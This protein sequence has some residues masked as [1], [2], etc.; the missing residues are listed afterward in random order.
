MKNAINVIAVGIKC[1]NPA[2][3]YIDQTVE[4]K[5]YPD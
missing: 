4:V 2:C 1:D 5:D 3:D